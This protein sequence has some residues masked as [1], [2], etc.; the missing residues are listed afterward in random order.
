MLQQNKV[1]LLGAKSSRTGK[2]RYSKYACA[3][4]YVFVLETCAL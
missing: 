2:Y 1:F 3:E 4:D